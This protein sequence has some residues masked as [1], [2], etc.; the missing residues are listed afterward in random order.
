M[1]GVQLIGT[2]AVIDRYEK[3]DC[4]SWAIFQGKEFI[5]GGVGAQSLR[6]WINDFEMTGSTATYKLRVYD[7]EEAPTSATANAAYVA[8]INFKAVDEYEGYGIAGHANKLMQRIE[9]L[10][11]K[12]KE[13]DS[14]EDDEGPDLNEIIMGWLTE[15]QKLGMVIGAVRQLFGGE[16]PVMPA[17]ASP[18]PLQTISGLEPG[19]ISP[20]SED[21]LMRISK[22]LDILGVCDP[23]LVVHLEKL[24]KLA[25][26]DKVLFKAVISKLDAL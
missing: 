19:K 15:P 20:M 25:E 7:Y 10:E 21:G 2:K 13:Q 6:E 3:L 17:V 1:T 14:D 8:S 12:L 18:A 5:V 26:T 11:K 16:M 9:G 22:A 23:D 24:A 4:E